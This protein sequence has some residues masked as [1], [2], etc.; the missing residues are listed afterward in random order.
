VTGKEKTVAFYTLGCKL[1]QFETFDLERQFVDRGYRVLP[2]SGEASVYVVN[3][4]TVTGKSDYRCRQTLRKARRRNPEGVVIAVGCYAQTQPGKLAGM[5]EVD[6]VLGNSEKGDIFSHLPEIESPARE[7]G[8]E[9]ATAVTGEPAAPFGEIA[10]FGNHTRAFVKIQDGCNSRCSYCI[11]PFARGASR[12][13]PAEEVRRQM[14]LLVSRGYR[15]IVLTGVHLGMWGRDLSPSD[16]LA[17]LLR[18][19]VTIP[20][21]ERLRLSSIEPTEFSPALLDI[22]SSERICPHLHVPLQSGSAKI[23]RAM[24]RPYTPERYADLIEELAGRLPDCGIGADVIVGF[25]GEQDEDF[26]A[27]R[28]LIDRLPLSYLHV[29]PYSKRP[30]TAA[31]TMPGEVPAEEVTRRGNE[32]R[33]LGRSKSSAY[34]RVRVGRTYLTL[35]EGPRAEDAKL[36]RGLTGNYLKVLADAP[37][38]MANTMV[39]LTLTKYEGGNLYGSMHE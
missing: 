2:F 31:A 18:S 6:F 17:Y 36:T 19:L 37:P 39:N 16:S 10:G 11:V 23:L 28:D 1:N 35:I 32:L 3:T 21:L 34:Q 12:S 22:L 7:D 29:F 8:G 38:E 13:R 33:R 20:G 4:C 30:G 24:R 25:P 9:A 26:L 27:T 5:P 15:E 14:G